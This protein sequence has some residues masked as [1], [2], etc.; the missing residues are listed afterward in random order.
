[1]I[2]HRVDIQ[3]Q[4][5]G[6]ITLADTNRQTS[7][8]NTDMLA[9]RG[10]SCSPRT[11]YTDSSKSTISIPNNKSQCQPCPLQCPLHIYQEPAG[12]VR[13]TFDSMFL[14]VK[15]AAC[16]NGSC[17]PDVIST[18]VWLTC[19]ANQAK[20]CNIEESGVED[21]VLLGRFRNSGML[22]PNP[23]SEFGF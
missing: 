9:V 18:S 23:G 12:P 8:K 6:T 1:M 5:K 22:I 19:I 2:T 17:S 21:V 16:Q 15:A 10:L 14:P 4:T 11:S 7:F 13:A 20:L 3:V